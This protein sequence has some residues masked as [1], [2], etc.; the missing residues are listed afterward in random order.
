MARYRSTKPIL[1]QLVKDGNN[2]KAS[3]EMHPILLQKIHKVWEWRKIQCFIVQNCIFK[4]SGKKLATTC[5]SREVSLTSSW[6]QHGYSRSCC[7]EIVI[8]WSNQT[9]YGQI[10]GNALEMKGIFYNTIQMQ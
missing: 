9:N 8:N 5:N 6:N 2:Y 7:F 1:K 10:C 3:D 4:T